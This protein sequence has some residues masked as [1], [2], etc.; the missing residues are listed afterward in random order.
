MQNQT[1][2]DEAKLKRLVSSWNTETTGFSGADRILTLLA[3]NP[4]IVGKMWVSDAD[5]VVIFSSIK[6]AFTNTDTGPA[7]DPPGLSR[8]AIA[9]KN[10]PKIYNGKE[11]PGIFLGG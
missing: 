6:A 2:A 7:R 10:D 1:T 3:I 5:L 4:Q 8:D 11:T 9:P